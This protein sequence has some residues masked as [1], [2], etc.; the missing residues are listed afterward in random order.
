MDSFHHRDETLVP[1]IQDGSH[2]KRG[3]SCYWQ[4]SLPYASGP[5]KLALIG[6]PLRSGDRAEIFD[7][8]DA[9]NFSV[10]IRTNSKTTRFDLV[11]GLFLTIS[12]PSGG[13]ISAVFSNN[14]TERRGSRVGLRIVH[15]IRN[16][17]A[18]DMLSFRGDC[19]AL[20]RIFQNMTAAM[21][22]IRGD[23]QLASFSSMTEIREF[24]AASEEL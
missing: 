11:A 7:R 13:H 23:A 24:V 22:S 21:S 1:L 3:I 4:V 12:L 20:S 2:G 19:Y 5:T 15:P 18:T 8:S 14:S 6:Q 9:M 17:C 16:H 10:Y